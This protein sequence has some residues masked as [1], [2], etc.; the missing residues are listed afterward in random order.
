M[1]AVKDAHAATTHPF[2]AALKAHMK[3]QLDPE[4]AQCL[5]LAGPG[6]LAAQGQHLAIGAAGGMAQGA[7]AAAASAALQ[8][9]LRAAQASLAGLRF[10][11]SGNNGSDA[12]DVCPDQDD[13][14]Y[15][16]P[17]AAAAV[18]SGGPNANSL[19]GQLA[20]DDTRAVQ[21]ATAAMTSLE[22]AVG[23]LRSAVF[24]KAIGPTEYEALRQHATRMLGDL[25]SL[26]SRVRGVS[27]IMHSLKGG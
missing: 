21:G 10:N 15:V 8:Q 19:L 3:R 16:G 23:A 12:M 1:C 9:S 17:P 11:Y 27:E 25:A 7:A 22:H 26:S 2:P 6:R 5:A 24:S 4:A 20:S 14:R 13:N 18:A